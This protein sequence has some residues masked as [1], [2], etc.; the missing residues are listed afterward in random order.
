M[1]IYEKLQIIRCTLQKEKFKKSGKNTYAGYEYFELGDFLPRINELML[2]HKLCS[3]ISFGADMAVLTIINIEKPEEQMIFTS[4]MSEAG[5][6]GCHAVQNLGA[7][8]TYLRRY[9][10]VNAFEIVEHDAL[11]GTTGKQDKQ[12][13]PKQQAKA[14]TAGII[15]EAQQKRLF[16]I[17]NGKTQQ[18]KEIMLE[19]GYTSSKDIKTKDYEAI[20]N[21]IEALNKEAS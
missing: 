2:E 13:Q 19:F 14:T 3:N 8:Q 11:D 1:N 20:C 10:Y 18:A 7:V 17:S 16:A 5:L 4:P 12:E 6:K 9:L 21:K 15:S